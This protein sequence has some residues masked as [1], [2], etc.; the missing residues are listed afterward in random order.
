VIIP[1]LVNN[2]GTWLLIRRKVLA[3]ERII[4]CTALL[5][6]LVLPARVS[7]QDGSTLDGFSVTLGRVGCLGMCPDYEV[8]ILGNGKVRYQGHS[9][10]RV[11][12][13]RESSIPMVDVQKLVERLE[14]E[15][16]FQWDGKGDLCVDYPQVHITVSL[17][18][19]RKRVV[20][21][22]LSPGKILALADE[23]DRISGTKRWV[24]ITGPDSCR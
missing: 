22:C 14:N 7:A 20:E 21:G 18:G 23:I 13:I 8:S 6:A 9:Y 12:G 15:H 4:V 10:V 19:Q 11:K 1:V 3:M 5:F 16:F 2:R 17:R 24:Q